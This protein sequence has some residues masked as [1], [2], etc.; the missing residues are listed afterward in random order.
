MDIAFN[1][2]IEVEEENDELV[3]EL[4]AN[5]PDLLSAESLAY[6]LRAYLGLEKP[7]VFTFTP[8]REET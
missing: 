8:P 2:G 1:Y 4:A 7:R 3:W 6:Y 5:R